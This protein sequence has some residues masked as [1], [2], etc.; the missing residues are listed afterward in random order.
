MFASDDVVWASL[1]FMADDNIP[2]LHHTN[3]VI[4][5]YVTARARLHLYS[6]L[7]RLQDRALYYDTESIVFVQPRDK[8]SLVEMVIF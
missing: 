6:Y 8:I 5:A 4:G 2:S 7:D 3:E 1:R